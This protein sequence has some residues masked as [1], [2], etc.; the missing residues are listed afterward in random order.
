[1]MH[2]RYWTCV[3]LIA[4]AAVGEAFA[5][6]QNP[7]YELRA[8]RQRSAV[9][10]LAISTS[11]HQGSGNQEVY[12]ADVVHEGNMH[13]LAKL[14]DTYPSSGRPVL[15]LIL[16]ERH[17]LQMTL[18]RNPE[19]DSTGQSFFLGTGDANIFDAETRRILQ[20]RSSETIPC[21]MVVHEATRL[22]K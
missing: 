16:A 20:D 4:L 22:A 12:L 15:R 2:P 17:L 3:L 19:C 10:I 18:I 11:V 6:A 5:S 14:V 21:F 13:Q 1:M 7:A 8:K 9:G